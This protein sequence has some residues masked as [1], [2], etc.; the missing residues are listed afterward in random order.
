MIGGHAR[1]Y[2]EFRRA[3]RIEGERRRR[4]AAAAARV[5]LACHVDRKTAR[6]DGLASVGF[7][8]PAGRAETI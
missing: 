2:R 8:E 5:S 1:R 6:T 7:K 3:R 4:R